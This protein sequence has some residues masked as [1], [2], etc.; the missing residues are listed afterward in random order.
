MDISIEYWKHQNIDR[1]KPI[2]ISTQLLEALKNQEKPINILID[3]LQEI[4]Y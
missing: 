2:Y 3:L 1:Q 4:K